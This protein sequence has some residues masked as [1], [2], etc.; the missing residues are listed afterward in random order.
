M[1]GTKEL[2][3]AMPTAS[4]VALRRLHTVVAGTGDQEGC[5]YDAGLPVAARSL[6]TTVVP[7]YRAVR[8]SLA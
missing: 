5:D 3:V 2:I 8:N 7:R 4:T 6:A 1:N